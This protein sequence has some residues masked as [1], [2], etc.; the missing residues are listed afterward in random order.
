MLMLIQKL[1]MCILV[2]PM[3][4]LQKNVHPS[5]AKFC[6]KET[7]FTYPNAF[8]DWHYCSFS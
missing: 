2:C 1:E 6:F 7:F 3:L 5:V 4:S 8:S